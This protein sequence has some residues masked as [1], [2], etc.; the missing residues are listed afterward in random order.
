MP[1]P[2]DQKI[3]MRT[4]GLPFRV[5]SEASVTLIAETIYDDYAIQ[6][7]LK[8]RGMEY[9]TDTISD[10]DALCEF[11]GRACYLSFNEDR[12][13]P[14]PEGEQNSTYLNHIREVGHGSVTEH[15]VWTFIIDDFSK[16]VTQELVR[17]RVGV[18]YSI[19]S[20]RYV[21]QFSNEYFGDSGHKLGVYIAPEIQ[22]DQEL[23]DLWINQWLTDAAVYNKTIDKLRSKGM[24]KKDVQSIARDILPNGMCNVVIFSVNARSLNH[25]FSMRGA[26]PAHPEFR[27]MVCRIWDYVKGH[28]LFKHWECVEHPKKG[29]YLRI[30]DDRTLNQKVAKLLKDEGVTHPALLNSIEYTLDQYGKNDACYTPPPAQQF[31]AEDRIHGVRK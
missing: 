3:P 4:G 1:V 7:W 9:D 5:V 6:D 14:A 25:L 12:R 19:Q 2:D 29:R 30:R 21:N 11:A 22:E 26:L 27:K 23:Y 20:S 24:D 15:P 28:N 13:R 17:H 10:Q 18:A 16:G 8:A 31:Q